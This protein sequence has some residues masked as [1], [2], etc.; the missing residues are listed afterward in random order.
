MADVL[1]TVNG[2][3]RGADVEPGQGFDERRYDGAGQRAGRCG[4]AREVRK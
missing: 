1:I 2:K 3:T 4:E